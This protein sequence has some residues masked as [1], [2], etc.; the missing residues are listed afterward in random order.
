M[1]ATAVDRGEKLERLQKVSTV[2]TPP[3]SRVF[4]LVTLGPESK[5]EKLQEYFQSSPVLC[6]PSI[7]AAKLT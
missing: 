2:F 7:L 3:E 1:E 6:F 5:P 4:V